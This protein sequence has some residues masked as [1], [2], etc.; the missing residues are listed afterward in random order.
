MSS[1]TFDLLDASPSVLM[2]V[3]YGIRINQHTCFGT[4]VDAS[5]KRYAQCKQSSR[6]S[7]SPI[8]QTLLRYARFDLESR[9][10]TL[11]IK[12]NIEILTHVFLE[13]AAATTTKTLSTH[14]RTFSHT[15]N[16]THIHTSETASR[17]HLRDSR[18][19]PQYFC[20]C[21]CCRQTE[22]RN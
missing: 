2:N 20:S 7:S 3:R 10:Q 17:Y 19:S 1:H 21:A 12:F 6:Q 22:D 5:R 13:S 15:L 11:Y 16:V 18:Q 8:I 4:S 14:H 9:P